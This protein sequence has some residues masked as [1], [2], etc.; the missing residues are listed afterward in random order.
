MQNK[1]GQC[2]QVSWIIARLWVKWDGQKTEAE[3]H[4]VQMHNERLG[5]LTHY[6][7][8][9]CS[10]QLFFFLYHNNNIFFFFQKEVGKA[11]NEAF[12]AGKTPC[13]DAAII[14]VMNWGGSSKAHIL[15]GSHIVAHNYVGNWRDP[16]WA[17]LGAL[18]AYKS[19][20]MF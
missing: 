4:L 6:K 16:V 3:I 9:H 1:A 20:A 19:A 14:Q 2:Y 8:H 12:D 18:Q 15:W 7:C 17:Q 10:S 11:L 13:T 5:K